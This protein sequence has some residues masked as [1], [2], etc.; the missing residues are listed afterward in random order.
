M[1]TI[2]RRIAL[3]TGASVAALGLSALSATPA[4]AAPHDTFGPS[5]TPAAGTDTTSD[6]VTICALAT[7]ADC[8][9]GVFATGTPAATANVTAPANGQI[10]QHDAGA[11][12]T[13]TMTN[14]AGDS[15]EVGA[16][17]SGTATANADARFPIHQ[18]ATGGAVTLN[19]QNS[20]NLLVDAVAVATNTATPAA[21]AN[22][23]ATLYAGIDQFVPNGTNVHI[24]L[25]N[26]GTYTALAR[27]VATAADVANAI[28]NVSYAIAQTAD[29]TTVNLSL[30]N[31]GTINI[32]ALATAAASDA[33]A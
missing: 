30:Q 25:T 28:A 19:I 5:A 16:I 2:N 1:T 32:S 7:N 8:F 4:L 27:A 11:T 14:A 3:L 17:A 21:S 29:A 6:T 10:Y 24:N 22:A 33:H 26:D 13:L 15:A 18:T 12:V 9:F 31:N 20:G 23:N